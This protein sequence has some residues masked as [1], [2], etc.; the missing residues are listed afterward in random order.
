MDQEPA[1]ATSS[2]R[3]H[4][5]LAWLIILSVVGFI[6][7]RQ[8][9]AKEKEGLAEWLVPLQTQSR[10]FVAMG[11]LKFLGNDKKEIH[12]QLQKLVDRTNYSQR[13]RLAI[14]S[15]ELEGSET[16]SDSFKQL[17]K[18]REAGELNAEETSQKAVKLL[19]RLYQGYQEQPGKITLSED[20]QKELR[21]GLGW[22][23]DLALGS[24]D[25]LEALRSRAMTPARRTLVAFVLLALFVVVGLLAG[26]FLMFLAAIFFF[27]GRMRSGFEV[28]T[29][30]GGIYAETFAVYMVLFIA[31]GWL[32]R[33][34]PESW[35][36]LWNSGLAMILSLG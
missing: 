22:F 26:L 35:S 36:G 24:R 9:T 2:P 10:Y 25:G 13:L 4:P 3:G 21:E 30:S 20:E 32:F 1:F 34:L 23:G 12:A 7:L 18:E 5:W 27:Q 6:L 31:I 19:Q 11:D 17:E 15:G 33:F 16:A 28:G 29:T 14:L 8:S